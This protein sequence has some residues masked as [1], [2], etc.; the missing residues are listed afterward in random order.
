M[1]YDAASAL[2]TLAEVRPRADMVDRR[3]H[4]RVAD[5]AQAQES[6]GAGQVYAW[7]WREGYLRFGDEMEAALAARPKTVKKSIDF[8]AALPDPW[9][10]LGKTEE[11]LGEHFFEVWRRVRVPERTQLLTL[12]GDPMPSR[13][14]ELLA[15][16]GKRLDSAPRFFMS[17]SIGDQSYTVTWMSLFA[18]NAVSGHSDQSRFSVRERD[19]WSVTEAELYELMDAGLKAPINLDATNTLQGKLAQLHDTFTPER[20]ALGQVPFRYQP[21][22]RRGELKDATARFFE[23]LD[24]VSAE[25]PSGSIDLDRFE[26][27]LA[28]S[29][30]LTLNAMRERL[31]Y[32]L[33]DPHDIHG[34]PMTDGGRLVWERMLAL[35]ERPERFFT[36]VVFDTRLEDAEAILGW[37][38]QHARPSNSARGHWLEWV[39]LPEHEPEFHEYV[40]THEGMVADFLAYIEAGITWEQVYDALVTHRLKA[41]EAEEVL[42]HGTPVEY[43]LAMRDGLT[44]GR[45]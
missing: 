4:P 11:E 14:A 22:R 21:G 20:R 13:S 12:A 39:I 31:G 18:Y 1:L 32:N 37:M 17:N 40:Q 29:E 23:H 19:R 10:V 41:H 7:V 2:R 3:K 27:A 38:P 28:D 30:G 43:V 15:W 25:A 26:V 16:L 35:S 24:G 33:P 44:D 34:L 45:K 42:L 36:G 8:V 6:S 9:M 5:Y